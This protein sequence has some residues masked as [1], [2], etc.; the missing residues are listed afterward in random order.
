M[1]VN[2]EDTLGTIE[3]KGKADCSRHGG[4]PMEMTVNANMT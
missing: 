4:L 2:K 1:A 3:R